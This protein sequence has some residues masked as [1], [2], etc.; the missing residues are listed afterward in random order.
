MKLPAATSLVLAVACIIGAGIL[1]NLGLLD[2]GVLQTVKELVIGGA[3]LG[4]GYAYA[5][6]SG[7]PPT[8]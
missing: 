1:V 4:G 2:E 8:E 7:K 3:G 5:R 6:L